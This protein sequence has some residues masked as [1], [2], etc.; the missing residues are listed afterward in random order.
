[1]TLREG[2]DPGHQALRRNFHPAAATRGR[3]LH[4][5]FP[6]DVTFPGESEPDQMDAWISACAEPFYAGP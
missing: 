2:D 3:I 5:D 1:V 4:Q 6:I